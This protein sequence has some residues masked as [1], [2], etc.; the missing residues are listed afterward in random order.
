VGEQYTDVLRPRIV[1]LRGLERQVRVLVERKTVRPRK[2]AVPRRDALEAFVHGDDGPVA[3][4]V[5][6]D[7]ADH[8]VRLVVAA[9]ASFSTDALP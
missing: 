8:V 4:T 3:R 6:G 5:P 7:G 1:V 2:E 9:N